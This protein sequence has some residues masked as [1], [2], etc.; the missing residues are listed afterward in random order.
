MIR[1]HRTDDGA[2][3]GQKL[4]QWCDDAEPKARLR[5]PELPPPCASCAFREGRHL[6]NGSP[7]TQMDALK[8]VLEGREFH[9]HE[10]V[11][12]GAICSGWAMMMLAEDKPDFRDVPWPFS[13]GET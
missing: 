10:P 4:A 1:N 12:E 2:E 3:I 9:C 7:Y 5:M 6:A 13:D 11:R 8:C